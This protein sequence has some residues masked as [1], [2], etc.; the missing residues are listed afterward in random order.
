MYHFAA[1]M[2]M[3]SLLAPYTW[4]ALIEASLESTHLSCRARMLVQYA[5]NA[6]VLPFLVPLLLHLVVVSFPPL[7]ILASFHVKYLVQTLVP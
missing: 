4:I 7:F 6:S 3:R 2:R 5:G 1:A